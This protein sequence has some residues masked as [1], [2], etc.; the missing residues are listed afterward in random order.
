MVTLLCD[1][2]SDSLAGGLESAAVSKK[3]KK[4]KSKPEVCLRRPR[5]RNVCVWWTAISSS[6]QVNHPCVPHLVWFTREL[7]KTIDNLCSR[8]K[9][10]PKSRDIAAM[11]GR[12]SLAEGSAEHQ[13]GPSGSVHTHTR[14]HANA[15]CMYSVQVGER[16]ATVYNSVAE[17]YN[18]SFSECF[19]ALQHKSEQLADILSR[20]E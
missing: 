3:Q 11:L 14:T 1:C 19:E 16:A 17:S 5:A 7:K 18:T 15:L 6:L 12:L 20:L 4:K 9:A 13:V 10:L 2:A 8:Q